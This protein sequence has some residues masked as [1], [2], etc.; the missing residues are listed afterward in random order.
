MS[1]RVIKFYSKTCAPCRVLDPIF[2]DIAEKNAH[3][4]YFM[5][6]DVESQ[7]DLAKSMRVSSVPTVIVE[8]NG[9]E[10]NRIIG[11]RSRSVYENAIND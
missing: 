10:V 5:N 6:V 8:K 9:V 1:I 2:Q 4:A 3:K 7:Q 11:L